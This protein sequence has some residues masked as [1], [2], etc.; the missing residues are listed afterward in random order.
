MK[1]R[2]RDPDYVGD[3][4]ATEPPTF[5]SFIVEMESYLDRIY[6]TEDVGLQLKK[7]KEFNRKSFEIHKFIQNSVIIKDNMDDV[8]KNDLHNLKYSL[9][10]GNSLIATI[11]D[12]NYHNEML[13]HNDVERRLSKSINILTFFLLLF[14]YSLLILD[15]FHEMDHLTFRIT[16]AVF[17]TFLYGMA[18]I[19]WFFYSRDDINEILNLVMQ[20]SIFAI[21]IMIITFLACFVFPIYSFKYL[22]HL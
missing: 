11:H 15:I 19:I 16:S 13:N 2:R 17:V 22:F 7:I 4:I 8:F 9:D 20:S 18:F 14:T 6:Q 10:S 5:R 21:M 1:E 3:Y 12:I